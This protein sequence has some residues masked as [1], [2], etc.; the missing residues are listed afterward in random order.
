MQDEADWQSITTALASLLSALQKTR[1][2]CTIA[3]L[4]R[5]YLGLTRLLSAIK[6]V[7]LE[8][9]MGSSISVEITSRFPVSRGVRRLQ[10]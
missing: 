3:M 6:T 1:C 5:E 7:R 8:V 2:F 4:A 10:V 9:V